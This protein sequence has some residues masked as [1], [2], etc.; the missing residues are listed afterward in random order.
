MSRLAVK[1]VIVLTLPLAAFSTGA[2][3]MAKLSD[4]DYV[5]QR[6]SQLPD[7][8]DRKPLNQRLCGYDAA[9]V[10]CHWGA[11]DETALRNERRFLRLD[12]VFPFL[13]GAALVACLWM[14]WAALGRPSPPAWLLAPVAVTVLA[15]WTEN[16]VQLAQLRRYVESGTAGLQPGWIQVA[17]T[18]TVLKLLFFVG[19][20]LF[21]VGLVA[22]VAIQ[23]GKRA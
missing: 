22:A 1:L 5:T 4:R 21:L 16:L 11:L 2:W 10:G 15:D 6:L 13:Y 19:T 7:A 3:I 8:R 14:A 23:A 12:L 20:V 9:A 18:A 17:S